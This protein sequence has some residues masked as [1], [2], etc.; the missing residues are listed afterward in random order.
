MRHFVINETLTIV[1]APFR[2]VTTPL[3]FQVPAVT[4]LLRA[5]PIPPTQQQCKACPHNNNKHLPVPCLP[6]THPDTRPHRTDTGRASPD[7]ACHPDPHPAPT[8]CRLATRPTTCNTRARPIPGM[9][10]PADPR[11]IPACRPACDH[12]TCSQ[13]PKTWSECR[14]DRTRWSGQPCSDR[15]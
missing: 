8:E 4:R 7:Q 11:P 15:G 9:G 14:P 12:H 1:A 6:G 13:D 3:S 5:C 2:K 10:T